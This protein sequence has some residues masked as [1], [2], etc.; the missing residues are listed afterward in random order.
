LQLD[1]ERVKGPSDAQLTKTQKTKRVV[2]STNETEEHVRGDFIEKNLSSIEGG[3]KKANKQWSNQSIGRESEDCPGRD[4]AQGS[5]AKQ[6][7][8]P[9]LCQKTKTAKEEKT[10]R[11]R[12][13][14]DPKA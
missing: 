10:K 13:A 4:G 6:E 5:A 12:F 8:S 14:D 7:R 2:R 9:H 11:H 1:L 3:Q